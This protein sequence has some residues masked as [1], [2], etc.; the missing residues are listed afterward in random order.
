MTTSEVDKPDHKDSGSDDQLAPDR[1]TAPKGTKFR[2]TLI[3]AGAA[4]VVIVLDQATKTLAL[5]RLT[6]GKP[7]HVIGTLEWELVYNRGS[8]FSLGQGLGPIIGMFALVVA[9]AMLVMARKAPKA[10]YAVVYGIVAGGAIGNVLDRLFRTGSCP[11]APCDGFMR[12]AVID[13]IDLNWWPVFNVA[14]MA[15]VCGVV[16]LAVG[17]V[18]TDRS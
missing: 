12:G 18:L 8:A 16:A 17:S 11:G 10:S 4:L 9:A 7:I 6:L 5:D 15:I 2:G 14:D 1:S 3:A 13:F